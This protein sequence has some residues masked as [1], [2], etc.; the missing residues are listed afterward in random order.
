VARP[1]LFRGLL[2]LDVDLN[3]VP[4][5]AAEFAIA[6][7]GLTY[8][9]QLRPDATWSDGVPVTAHDFAYTFARMQEEGAQLGRLLDPI[10][11]AV[12]VDT[13]T[14]EITLR[15]PSNLFLYLLT[16]PAGFAWPRHRCELLGEAW[17]EPANLVSNGPFVLTALGEHAATLEARGDWHGPRGN[18]GRASLRLL[19]FGS[20]NKDRW[21]LGEGDLVASNTRRYEDDE[22]T[23]VE[24]GPALTTWYTGFRF[25]VPPFDDVRVRRAFAHALDVDET[26]RVWTGPAQPVGGGGLLP[27]QIPGHSHRIGLGHDPELARVLLA[28][29]GYP[30]GR[31]MPELIFAI[32]EGVN[33]VS[34]FAHPFIEA[35]EALGARVTLEVPELPRMAEVTREHAH[36]WSWG[37][38]AEFP[39][40]DGFLRTFLAE[41]PVY[42]GPEVRELLERVATM[43]EQEERLRAYREIDRL[44]VAE[45]VSLIPTHYDLTLLVSRPWIRGK[46]V[47]PMMIQAPLD[48]ITVDEEARNKARSRQT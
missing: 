41:M 5:V 18:V 30:G 40:P 10:A 12:A 25:E 21:E 9:F 33:E 38:Q 13:K 4:D 29:A 11:S 8:R 47:H 39:D 31:G 46:V 42:Q 48:W 7:D 28:D 43:D 1:Q 6:A 34:T 36:L 32:D 26:A 19:P 44:L 35:W 37:W 24:V 3:V 23:R 16:I 45:D 27:P 14:L 2:T 17:R 20:S 22:H 15:S